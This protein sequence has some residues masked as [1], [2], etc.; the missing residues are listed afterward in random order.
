MSN[1]QLERELID[2]EEEMVTNEF[3][4]INYGNHQKNHRSIMDIER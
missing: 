1:E 3:G 2:L 4:R